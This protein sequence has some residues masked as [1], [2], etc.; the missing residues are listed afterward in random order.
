M[1]AGPARKTQL[2]SILQSYVALPSL[3]I[4]DLLEIE[5]SNSDTT[6]AYF[7][8][9]YKCFQLSV[10]K[11]MMKKAAGTEDLEELEHAA[12]EGKVTLKYDRRKREVE[13]KGTFEPVR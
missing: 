10:F 1:H 12:E 8:P 13:S 9:K 11:K 6:N 3:N 4:F 5:I 2:L 7:G